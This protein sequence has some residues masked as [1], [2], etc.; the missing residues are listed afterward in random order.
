MKYKT[1]PSE[2]RFWEKVEKTDYC[3]NWTAYKNPDGYGR[4][5]LVEK[6]VMAHQFSYE[7]IK[8]KI[9]KG[10]QIDHLCRNRACVNPDHLEA[11]NHKE[12]M[13]RGDSAKASA[14]Y[15]KS[16]THCP[17]GHPY[18]KENTHMSKN[19]RNCRECDKIRHR[20]RFIDQN[21]DSEKLED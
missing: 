6:M 12:N 4:F 20:K 19:S 14:E 16:K 8:G 9:P 10:L 18:S 17:Q 7:S 13:R 1:K 21:Y 15:Q 2:Q 5:R 3:W 11:V